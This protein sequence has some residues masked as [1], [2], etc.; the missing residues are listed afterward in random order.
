MPPEERSN[1]RNISGTS[2][3]MT[4]LMGSGSMQMQWPWNSKSQTQTVPKS[5]IKQKKATESKATLGVYDSS[6]GGNEGH[7][8]FILNKAT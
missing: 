1:L 4:A 7:L 2:L 6:S 8:S 5:P 3:T